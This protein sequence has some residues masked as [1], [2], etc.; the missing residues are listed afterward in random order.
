[1]RLQELNRELGTDY[2]IPDEATCADTGSDYN[3]VVEF[4]TSMTLDE[5]ESYIRDMYE[6]YGVIEDS[7]Y[8]IVDKEEFYEYQRSLGTVH[9]EKNPTD[10]DTQG[11]DNLD[12]SFQY[13]PWD[14]EDE[15]CIYLGED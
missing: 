13:M 5:F 12:P 3:E 6:Q 15:R 1:M 9:N 2:A 4:Y 11:T 14:M 10:T 7:D 8:R